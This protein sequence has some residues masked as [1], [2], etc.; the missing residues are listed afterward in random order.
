MQVWHDVAEID[1]RL[2]SSVVTIGNFDGVH[3]GHRHVVARSR[4]VATELGGLPVVA[5]TFDPHPLT[6]VAPDKAPQMLVSLERRLAL[7]ATAGA[8]AVLV[9]AFTPQFAQLSAE[10]F[11][12]DLVLGRLSAAAV[13]VGENFRFGR[14]ALGDVALLRRLCEPRG[15]RV[16]GLPLDGSGG[17]DSQAWSSSYIRERIGSGDVA[18][19]AQALGRPFSVHGRVVQGEQ[20]GRELGYPTANVPVATSRTAIPSDGVYVGWLR[21]LDSADAPWWPA[22]I[23]VGTNPTFDGHVRH[24]ETYVLD[25]TDLELYGVDVEVAFVERL[26]GQVRFDSIDDLVEQM[27]S[28]VDQSRTLLAAASPPGDVGAEP[29]RP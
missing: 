13:V 28:D 2:G 4:E 16:V 3:L 19:A 22:A 17:R 5:V 11:V 20:R 12:T 7:L 27:K 9:V 8:D 25:R 21:R 29:R 24:V 15:V 10:D 18:A 26:R 6:V 23:S 14:R 1:A